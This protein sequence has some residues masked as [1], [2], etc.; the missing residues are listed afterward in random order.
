MARQPGVHQR[1]AEVDTVHADSG[2][3]P[4]VPVHVAPLDRYHAAEDRGAGESAGDLAEG[5]AAFG[6]IDAVHADPHALAGGGHT[7]VDGVAVG[8]MDDGAG[9]GGLDMWA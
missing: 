6:C 8:H 7:H 5:L 4:A 1:F 3:D 9:E 2:H